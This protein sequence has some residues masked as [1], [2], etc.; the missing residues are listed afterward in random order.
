MSAPKVLL[1]F[2][3][4]GSVFLSN[5]W[6]PVWKKASVVIFCRL[7]W[8]FSLHLSEIFGVLWSKVVSSWFGKVPFLLCM[9]LWYHVQTFFRWDWWLREGIHLCMRW[10][11]T[12]SLGL[13]DH[14]DERRFFFHWYKRVVLQ[15]SFWVFDFWTSIGIE[16]WT[17]ISM[18]DLLW[19]Y[20]EANFSLVAWKLNLKSFGST[21]WWL[22]NL[23][24]GLWLSLSGSKWLISFLRIIV[25]WLCQLMIPCLLIREY[26][27]R[28]RFYWFS[29]YHHT[30]L[31]SS[32][33]S[34]QSSSLS[35]WF[36]RAFSTHWD[37][38]THLR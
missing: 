7:S 24:T 29:F 9:T 32:F 27:N 2:V 30:S 18:A 35:Q 21:F 10:G 12:F 37:K 22:H 25:I 33:R 6:F 19:L 8:S 17:Y 16:I 34:Y 3:F 38:W 5:L 36:W 23:W 31:F 20:L 13:R 26:F 14:I 11:W 15:I 4:S 28:R 1:F